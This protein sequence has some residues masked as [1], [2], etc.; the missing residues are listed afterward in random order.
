MVS[1]KS[2]ICAENGVMHEPKEEKSHPG[3]P[4]KYKTAKSLR[5]AVD[6]Y[7]RSIS[8]KVPMTT[9][10]GDPILNEDG[11][12]VIKTE[13]II[14]PQI[15]A[16]CLELGITDRT[17]RRY[18]DKELHPEFEDVT[19]E[20]MLRF[21]AYLV[22]QSLTREKGLQGILFNLEVNHGC[23]RKQEI[24]LGAKTRA[25]LP[26]TEMSIEEKMAMIAA[27]AK[28]AEGIGGGDE[29]ADE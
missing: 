14:P 13:Y 5:K 27:A 17:W 21:K 23:S 11:K 20:A 25:V 6:K 16:M 22:D 2:V 3:A 19:E 12:P 24:E 28:Y 29:D 8:V 26:K 15:P 10:T 4:Q 1:E 7:F 18:C 9:L